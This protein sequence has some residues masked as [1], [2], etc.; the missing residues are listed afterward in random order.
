MKSEIIYN[1]IIQLSTENR[2][3]L[4]SGFYMNKPIL[5]VGA[6][7][8]MLAEYGTHDELILQN[9]KYAELFNMQSQFYV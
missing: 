1:N 2:A 7:N 8:G 6:P 4:L 9:G 5:A 3:A